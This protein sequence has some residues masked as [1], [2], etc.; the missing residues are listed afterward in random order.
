[1]AGGGAGGKTGPQRKTDG[2]VSV[3]SPKTKNNAQTWGEKKSKSFGF[4][5]PLC[6]KVD[7][8]WGAVVANIEGGRNW[9]LWLTPDNDLR[10]KKKKGGEG[11][12]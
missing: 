7:R 4:C 1:M 5:Q 10:E 2:D 11:G 9:Y 8:M 3:Q 6:G 12:K